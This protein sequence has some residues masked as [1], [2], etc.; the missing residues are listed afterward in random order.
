MEKIKAL[1][2]E[3]YLFYLISKI[4]NVFF[5]AIKEAFMGSFLMSLWNWF[6][7]YVLN[8]PFVRLVFDPEYIA[9]IWYKSYFY[10]STTLRIR[11]LS[12]YLPRAS[13]KFSSIYIGI[14]IALILVA[15][16]SLWSDLFWMP[17]FGAVGLFYISRNIR[18]RVGTVFTLVNVILLI[19]L[20]IIEIT[21][22]YNT[23][24][25]IMYLLIGID[26]FFL[27]S[28]AVRTLED[29]EN[30]LLC[31]FA[32]ALILCGIGFMQNIMF[33]AAATSVF[34]DGV[35]LGEILMLIFPFAFIYPI[36]YLENPRKTIYASFIFIMFFNII[37]AT[38]SKAAL[39]GFVVELVILILANI[40]FLPFLILLM[41]L[42]LNSLIENIRTTWYAATSYGNIIN[43]L[44]ELSRKIWT[45][46]FGVDSNRLMSFY[47]AAEIRSA[48]QASAMNF[49]YLKISPVYI[50]FVVD[51]GAVLMVLFLAYILRLAHSA[52]TM[53]FT[54]DKRY[55]RFFTAGLAT[56]VAISVS[57]FFET[58]IFASRTMLIYW[59]MLGIIRA[60]RIMN[61]GIYES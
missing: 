7:K 50:N 61:F 12:Y 25:S 42:G 24:M 39:I 13:F 45:F 57:S 9:S 10:R 34:K 6:D 35:S 26:L 55:K 28:F 4:K 2:F 47:N 46:G 16:D 29:L 31:M 14:F 56:L 59:A 53:L 58:T 60:V 23:I 21:L 18:N 1:Y 30:I 51:I 33:K 22:P 44:I 17:L 43:N 8:S 3:S 41:P 11:K 52:F 36:E 54:G 5:P 49:N 48:A 15:P 32:A 38:Q 40:K 20:V 27:I 19:F 37:M